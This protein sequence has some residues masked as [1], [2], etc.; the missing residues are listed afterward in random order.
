MNKKQ[1]D[2]TSDLTRRKFVR[3]SAV[4]AVGITVG[5]SAAAKAE[6]ACCAKAACGASGPTPGPTAASPVQK[7][8]SYNPKMQYKPMG[9]TGE[10]VSKV[11]LGGH[12]KRLDKM[13]PGVF[14]GKA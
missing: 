5:L 9:G 1:Y 6:K 3:D 11:C 12:W 4:T 10:W 13:V 8:R 14:E 2:K 7:T